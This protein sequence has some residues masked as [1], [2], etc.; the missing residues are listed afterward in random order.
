MVAGLDF[1]QSQ[2]VVGRLVVTPDG[3][4]RVEAEAVAVV[5]TAGH[6]GVGTASAAVGCLPMGS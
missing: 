2:M 1:R 3:A 5:G 4:V 6:V